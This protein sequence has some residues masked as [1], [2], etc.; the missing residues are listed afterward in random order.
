LFRLKLMQTPGFEGLNDEL[1][2]MVLSSVDVP[3]G[4][5]LGRLFNPLIHRR[6]NIVSIGNHSGETQDFLRSVEITGGRVEVNHPIALEEV[7]DRADE[8]DKGVVAA[9]D[10]DGVM[11]DVEGEGGWR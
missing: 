6:I 7:I 3:A 8:L 2:S 5:V 1:P 11:G 4:L 9:G 10:L